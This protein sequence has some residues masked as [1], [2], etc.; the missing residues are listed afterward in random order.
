M[1]IQMSL[2][3][4]RS[5]SL[6]LFNVQYEVQLDVISLPISLAGHEVHY[7]AF[8]SLCNYGCYGD[9]TFSSSSLSTVG[10]DLSCLQTKIASPVSR[11]L[12]SLSLSC[13]IHC[14]R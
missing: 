6:P 10:V 9:F 4:A 2:L 11:F 1:L 13:A 14:A 12:S 7:F 5:S 8:P 3:A